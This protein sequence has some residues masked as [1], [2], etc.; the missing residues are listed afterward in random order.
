MT[1]DDGHFLS[2]EQLRPGVFVIL[3][4]AW[5]K[6]NFTLNSFKIR[7]E[8]QVRA[9]RELKLA[10]YRYDPER[11]DGVEA[12]GAPAAAT[13][14]ELLANAPALVESATTV[15]P[16]EQA[17]RESLAAVSAWRDRVTN[18]ERAFGKATAVM[19]NLNR[20]LLARPKET[21]EEMGALVGQMVVAFLESPDATLQVMGDKAGG[22]EVYFHSLNVTILSMMLAKDLGFPVELARE[23]GVGAMVHDIGLMDIPDRVT[24]KNPDD[25]NNAERT[26]RNQHVEYGLA[27]GR[28]IGLSPQALAVVG[29][30]HEMVDGGGFPKGTKG[31]SMTPAARVV[32]VVNAYDNLCN[33]IDIHKAMTPHE[34]LSYLYAKRRDKYDAK[35]LQLMIRCLGVYP[36]G[37]IVQLSDDALAVVTSVNPKKPLRPWIMVY[38]AN[39]PKEKAIMLDLEK[40]SHVNIVKSIRPALLTPKVAAYL[41]PRKR[42]TYFFDG[43]SGGTP[44]SA[45]QRS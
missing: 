25:Y 20:N 6:H 19:K 34:A 32:A 14:A 36:P 9:L 17:R 13:P 33:P 4:L 29:Q 40:E 2:A 30:H 44:P 35:V 15:D 12:L 18:V 42:V 45:P 8:D 27:I 5:F 31:E 24:K 16:A 3:D 1:A 37:S 28:K 39:V 43:G 26:L 11:S 38:D 7:N 22:E 41:N 10:R 23:M 21:L